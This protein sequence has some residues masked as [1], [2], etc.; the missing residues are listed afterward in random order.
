MRRNLSTLTEN[1][2]N[3]LDYYISRSNEQRKDIDLLYQE[4]KHTTNIIDNILGVSNTQTDQPEPLLRNLYYRMDILQ[5][6]NLQNLEDVLVSVSRDVLL[7]NTKTILFSEV[8]NPLNLSCPIQLE[9]FLDTDVLTQIIGCGHLFFPTGLERWF[10]SHAHCPM[11][12]YDIRT[13][14]LSE[15]PTSSTSSSLPIQSNYSNIVYTELDPSLNSLAEQIIS[16]LF[17][18]RDR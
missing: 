18:R 14:E 15:T 9:R 2:R 10:Q 3:I 4:L 13:N 1:D 5:P 12:R 7:R 16:N 17:S 11:C 6:Q 8:E